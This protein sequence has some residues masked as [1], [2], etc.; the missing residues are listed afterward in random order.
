MQEY[1][2]TDKDFSSIFN[3]ALSEFG[4]KR[5]DPKAGFNQFLIKCILK[6]LLSYLKAKNLEIKEGKIYVGEKN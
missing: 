2:L 6:S 3:S 5:I 1:E 4:Q